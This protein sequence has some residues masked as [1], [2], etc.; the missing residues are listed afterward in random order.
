MCFGFQAMSGF[1]YLM[2]ALANGGVEGGE[3]RMADF[4]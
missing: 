2:N 1:R 4:G 3:E